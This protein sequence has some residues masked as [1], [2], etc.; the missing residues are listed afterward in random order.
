MSMSIC[1]LCADRNMQQA[2]GR[3][4]GACFLCVI[5]RKEVY[6]KS[7]IKIVSAEERNQSL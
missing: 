1:I 6:N 5:D 3:R 2:S 4:P 7:C